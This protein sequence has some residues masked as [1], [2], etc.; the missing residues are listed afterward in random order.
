[1]TDFAR[2]PV[3]TRYFSG[4]CDYIF[5]TRLGVADPPLVDYLSDLLIRFVR[6]DALHRVRGPSGTPAVEVVEMLSEAE[7]RVGLAKRDVHQQIGDVT[8]FWTGL[9]P[10]ASPNSAGST[11]KICLSILQQGKRAYHI[12]ATSPLIAQPTRRRTARTAQRRFDLLHVRPGGSPPRMGTRRREPGLAVF[13]TK[14][15]RRKRQSRCLGGGEVGQQRAAVEFANQ[16]AFLQRET[17]GDE[18][19]SP[20]GIGDILRLSLGLVRRGR[21]CDFR[22]YR[23]RGSFTL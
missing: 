18:S 17:R 16:F 3:L 9:Y 19:P 13:V 10:E 22:F 20:V 2:G 8:L 21:L 15:L 4:L 12:A 23:R 5:A 7:N 11:A 1:M 14:S 6:N